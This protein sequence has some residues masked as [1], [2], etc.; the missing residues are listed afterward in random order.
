MKEGWFRR[1]YL[2]YFK[3]RK[4]REYQ[5]KREGSCKRCGQCC[6]WCPLYDRKNKSCRIYGFRP[7]IC[8][9]F[10]LSPEDLKTLPDCGYSFRN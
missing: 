1:R 5:A 4:V 8:R 2:W 3:R 9:E 6:G 7:A 10:P